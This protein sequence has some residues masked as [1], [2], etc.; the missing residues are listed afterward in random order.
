MGRLA[1]SKGLELLIDGLRAAKLNRPV[2]LL[3]AG[4]GSPDY[5]ATLQGGEG[6]PVAFIGKVKPEGV[7]FQGPLD[8]GPIRLGRT[9]CSE[10]CLRSFAHGIP[11]LGTD[12]GGTL[13]DPQ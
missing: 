6:L 3:V 11:V 5:V 8:C 12:T 7:L 13:I 2:E 9:A 1:P 4:E 10:C